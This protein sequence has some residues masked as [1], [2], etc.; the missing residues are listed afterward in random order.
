M[1]KV[2]ARVPIPNR[3]LYNPEYDVIP[4]EELMVEYPL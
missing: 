1:G 3:R 2:C 4:I